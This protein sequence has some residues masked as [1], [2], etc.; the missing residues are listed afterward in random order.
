MRSR[1]TALSGKGYSGRPIFARQISSPR[2]TPRSPPG[3][4]QDEPKFPA[5]KNDSTFKFAAAVII[6]GVILAFVNP[7][8][9][10]SALLAPVNPVA[11]S[12]K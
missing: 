4:M 8:M 6:A 12:I 1:A 2:E 3:V 9:K 11:S 7:S 5:M 10:S